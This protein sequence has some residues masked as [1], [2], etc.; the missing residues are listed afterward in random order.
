VNASPSNFLVF[1]ANRP[2]SLLFIV[3]LQNIATLHASSHY[4]KSIKVVTTLPSK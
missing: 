1:L 4:H 2:Y 3:L